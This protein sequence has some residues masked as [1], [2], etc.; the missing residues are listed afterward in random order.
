MR[1]KLLKS[2]EPFITQKRSDL[3]DS[4]LANRTRYI[5]VALEDIY[6]P[7]NASAVL[8]TCDCFGIQDVHII[9]NRNLYRVNP[10]VALGADKWL[11]LYKYRNHENNT[12]E[13][14]NRLKYQGYRIVATSLTKESRSIEDFD[15]HKSKFALFFGTELNGLSE[16]VN[17]NADEFIK[18]PM[19]GFTQSFNISVSAAIILYHFSRQMRDSGILWQLSK[20]EQTEL[21]IKWIKQGLRNPEKTEEYLTARNN[22]D[23]AHGNT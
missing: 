22:G 5:V 14:I 6:Q 23:C 8:R 2:L 17:Q 9:E 4:V 10:D 12:L 3:I 19:A 16:T 7:H 21:K 11:T 13:A 20:E 18:I 15:I 1:E